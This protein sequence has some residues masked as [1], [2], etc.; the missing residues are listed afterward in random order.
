VDTL[1]QSLQLLPAIDISNGQSVRV[2]RNQ[3]ELETLYGQPLEIAQDFISQ[4]SEWIHL[5]DLDQAF[6]NGN[7]R[8]VISEFFSNELDF[9]IQ[10]SGGIKNQETL[11][12]ALETRATRINLSTAALVNLDWVSEVVRTHADRIV[13]GLDVLGDRL[14]ARGEAVDAGN[15]FETLQL[16]EKIGVSRYL[17]TDVT[18]DGMMRGPNIELLKSI[19]D[20]TQS[21]VVASGGVS[22]LEDIEALSALVERGLEGLVLGKALYEGKFSLTEALEVVG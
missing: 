20:V 19:L 13:I 17:V 22:S 9:R 3:I 5:V 8:S 21:P 6:D 10:L 7:N 16:L 12:F 18:K 1:A 11:N 2:S 15:L 4:G 14:I